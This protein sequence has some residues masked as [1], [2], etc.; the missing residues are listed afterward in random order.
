MA[1]YVGKNP[2]KLIYTVSRD[3]KQTK[4]IINKTKDL[5]NWAIENNNN[6]KT[7]G[8][9]AFVFAPNTGDFDVSTYAWLEGAGLLKNKDLETYYRDVLVSKDKQ[10]YYNIAKEE[11]AFLASSG[12]TLARQAIIKSS[13][14]KRNALKASNP[15]LEPALTAGGNEVGS[16]LNMLTGIEQILIDNK[17]PLD[18]GTKQRMAMVTSRVRKFVALAN[19]PSAR[20]MTN[21][22]EIKRDMKADIQALI[23]DLQVG[24]PI[25]K[26]A[27][28]AVFRAVLDYY[29]RDTYTARE[30][31]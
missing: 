6:I 22:S 29:S 25:L 18:A 4:V 1:T 15:L 2:G 14:A 5:K 28:R 30:R 13:T 8:E 7:Y 23:N 17:I 11:K 20:E 24:D 19:D 10:E 31:F 26:E 21:F 9:A 12:D 27:N 16:E 3:D